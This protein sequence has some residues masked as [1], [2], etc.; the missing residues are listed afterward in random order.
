MATGLEAVGAASAVIQLISFAG[1]LVSLS[2]KI[3]DGIPTAEN[4]IEEYAAKTSA[5]MRCV[6]SRI[7]LVPQSTPAEKR[8]SAAAQSCIDAAESLNKEAHRITKRY[9]KGKARKA[10]YAALRG[11]SDRKRVEDLNQSLKRCRE[12]LETE[13]LVEI[14]LVVISTFGHYML[15]F[16]FDSDQGA[17]AKQLQSQGFQSLEIDIQNFLTQL[18]RGNT[19]IESLLVQEAETTRDIISTNLTTE[20]RAHEDRT[21]S[22][23]QRQRLLKSLKS[24][25]IRQ[26]YN[27][28]MSPSE[29]CFERV[30]ASYERV[31]SKDPE[32]KSWSKIKKKFHFDGFVKGFARGS[33][34]KIGVEDVDEIDAHWDTFSSWLRSSDSIFWVQGKPGSGKSTLMKFI[35]GND[36]T[37]KLL[38]SI[39]P[40]IR[41]LSHFFWKIGQETQNSIKGLICSLLHDILSEDSDAIDKILHQHRFCLAKDFYQEWSTEEAKEV[42]FSVLGTRSHLTCIFIDGLD[43][44]SDKDGFRKLLCVVEKLRLSPNVK[45]CVSSRP[46]TEIVKSLDAIR[47]QSLRLEDLTR[48]EM[49]LYVF[50]ELEPYSEHMP[51]STLVRF[52]TKLVENAQGVFLW[53]VLVTKSLTNGIKNGDDEKTLSD[54]L[55][56]LP[57]ELQALYEAMWS[58]LNGDNTVYREIAAKYFRCHVSEKSFMLTGILVDG[59]VKWVAV[60]GSALVMISLVMRGKMHDK[61]ESAQYEETLDALTSM[62]DATAADLEIR[63]AGMLRID[64]ESVLE[65]FRDY[66][67]IPSEVFHLTRRIQFIHRTAHDFLV[68]TEAGQA[69]LNYKSSTKDL[70]DLHV[71]RLES[72]LCLARFYSGFGLMLNFREVLQQCVR[73]E[74]AG[75]SQQIVL[76]LANKIHDYGDRGVLAY[77]PNDFYPK[78]S[79][80]T[81]FA[82]S[83]KS[84]QDVFLSHYIRPNTPEAMSDGL[85]D[86]A[87]ESNSLVW[88]LSFACK[89]PPVDLIEMMIA[90]GGDPHAIGESLLSQRASQEGLCVAERTTAFELFL[91]GAIFT[92]GFTSGPPHSVD[93]LTMFFDMLY[94]IAQACPHWDR[95]IL[96]PCKLTTHYDNTMSSERCPWEVFMHFDKTA[97]LWVVHEVEIK[98]L[99][100][101]LLSMAEACDIPTHIYKFHNIA[102]FSTKP[103]GRIRLLGTSDL[104]IKTGRSYRVVDQQPFED[105]ASS[106][107]NPRGALSIMQTTTMDLL[108]VLKEFQ[109]HHSSLTMP[110]AFV[111]SL[112]EVTLSE[113]LELLAQEGLLLFNA[114]GLNTVPLPSETEDPETDPTAISISTEDGPT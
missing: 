34:H 54:R 44:I 51:V 96:I 33:E 14:W 50:G 84:F 61:L 35:I 22:E 64:K 74:H 13:L 97:H 3:Y 72:W 32:H 92:S 7:Q 39:N 27:E 100:A 101:R 68:D 94:P 30:F 78:Y 38:E 77:F 89:T 15:I 36:N 71:K 9:Q 103:Q 67:Q 1:T 56:G 42:L 8:L 109:P 26:R 81:V 105:L 82:Y 98:S 46:E 99:F 52:M 88:T 75:T 17:A 114:T 55:H 11:S 91:R 111:E 43:E 49:A 79:F 108:K 4:E 24:Q 70:I 12:L 106:L 86:I 112:E 18:A 29:A 58:R 107:F 66:P 45:V 60:Y 25:E 62:C 19:K 21:V 37:K 57:S 69:I 40:N 73:L 23:A 93:D 113:G 31:C 41:I 2:L 76:R 80:Q 16:W 10:V 20:L 48:P 83:L 110:R 65:L 28:V 63:C 47:A 87:A 6:Q 104:S 85:R 59:S 95:K 90:L 5:A 102:N 53:L